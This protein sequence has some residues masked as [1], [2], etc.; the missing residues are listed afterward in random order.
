VPAL[1]QLEDALILNKL[2]LDTA[3][4]DGTVANTDVEQAYADKGTIEIG[5]AVE[6][7]TLMSCSGVPT[8]ISNVLHGPS[9]PS[10]RA[11]STH[12]KQ[13]TNERRRAVLQVF[14]CGNYDRCDSRII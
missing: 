8:R 5:E 3:Q 2:P 7:R 4:S 11:M 10:L 13:S 9:F 12:Y 6:I 1:S 14:T